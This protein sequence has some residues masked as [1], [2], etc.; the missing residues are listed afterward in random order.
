MSRQPGPQRIGDVLRDFLAASGLD[1]PLKHLEV[2][3]AWEEV[4][5][6]GLAPHTRIAGFTRHKLYVEVDSTAHLH[7]LRTFYK[8]KILADLQEKVPTILIQDI[9]FRPAGLP[10]T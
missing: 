7:E 6:P 5:G 9:V 8:S 1:S 10:R 2:Y 4:V 3:C